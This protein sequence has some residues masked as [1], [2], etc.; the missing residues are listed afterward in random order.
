MEGAREAP[1][2]GNSSRAK[3]VLTNQGVDSKGILF[4]LFPN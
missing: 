3:L 1:C 4:G 2:L